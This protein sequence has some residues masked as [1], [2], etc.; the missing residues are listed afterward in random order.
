MNKKAFADD[1]FPMLI[2]AGILIVIV[3]GMIGVS[4]I[5]KEKKAQK[6]SDF[7]ESD[8]LQVMLTNYLKSN[9][10]QI[11]EII[12]NENFD[13]LQQATEAYF[14][15]LNAQWVVCIYKYGEQDRSLFVSRS[16]SLISIQD[17]LSVCHAQNRA[18]AVMYSKSGMITVSLHV[19]GG[20]R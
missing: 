18:E 13:E 15:S 7:T 4:L 19:P 3:I 10:G 8:R 12:A 16:P 5:L 1:F 14:T 2:T 11:A 6:I 9:E 17:E 20:S